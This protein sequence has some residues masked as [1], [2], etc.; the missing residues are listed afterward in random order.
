MKQSSNSSQNEIPFVD[1]NFTS[2]D[3]T[4]NYSDDRLENIY[5]NL[6]SLTARFDKLEQ[7]NE[8]FKKEIEESKHRE[9]KLLNRF[10][11]LI[12]ILN[13]GSVVLIIMA[14]ILFID[15]FYP[16]IKKLM[17]DSQGATIV[18]GCIGTAI[19]GGIIAIWWKFNEYVKKVIERERLK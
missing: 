5:A 12:L 6:S 16:F 11:W 2:S 3:R 14:V 1:N 7:N 18:I 13:I 15:A 10:S 17:E 8:A 19:S 9:N 4:S